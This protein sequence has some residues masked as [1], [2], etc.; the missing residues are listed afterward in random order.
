MLEDHESEPLA[1]VIAKLN[2]DLR[3]ASKT[4]SDREAAFLV[5]TYY[6]VQH[7]RITASNQSDSLSGE[8]R[9]HEL[10]DW[11]YDQSV[12]LEN[13]IKAA[14]DL[15]SRNHILGKW[16][17]EQFGIG[18][19]ITAGLLA[20]TEMDHLSTAGKLC[21][22]AGIIPDLKWNKG[23]KRPY[24]ANL[25]QV[26]Y[27]ISDS[28]VKFKSNPKCF[29]GHLYENK[30]AYYT[31]QNE[32]GAYATRAAEK[33]QKNPNGKEKSYHEK[34]MLSIGHIDLMARRWTAK[35]FLCHYW[36]VSYWIT[37]EIRPPAAYAIGILHHV[38]YI[39]PPG[40]TPPK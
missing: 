28:M 39:P 19:V 23:E 7:E 5:Q 32:S 12:I 18:P 26:A 10:I 6:R 40:F 38:D 8:D 9:P 36:E 14:L 37:F 3:N 17:R 16:P 20:H 2:R 34:G 24:N 33:L 22:Y 31:A 25:K 30:K 13:Q 15:Y 4:L 21:A 29:Y 27:K 1:T 35:M 11:F